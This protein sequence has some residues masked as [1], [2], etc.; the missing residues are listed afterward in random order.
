[1]VYFAYINCCKLCNASIGA[2][3]GHSETLFPW[4]CHD[5]SVPLLPLA[6]VIAPELALEVGGTA[7]TSSL[8]CA[9]IF[10]GGEAPN[11][12]PLFSGLWIIIDKVLIRI[13]G[14]IS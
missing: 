10:L 13:V 4:V 3:P 8:S 11:Y 6:C 1:M 12:F 14:T 2:G 7:I 9:F 5:L